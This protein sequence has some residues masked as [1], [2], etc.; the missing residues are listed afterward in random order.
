MKAA[1]KIPFVKRVSV[2]TEI[3]RS[4][5]NKTVE[6]R[7]DNGTAFS[8]YNCPVYIQDLNYSTEQVESILKY[9]TDL[10]NQPMCASSKK[11]RA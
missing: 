11:L 5:R 8:S 9:L 7:G 4:V 2:E 1:N 3:L 10:E 6:I